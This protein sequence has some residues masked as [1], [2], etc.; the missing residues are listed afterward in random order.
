MVQIPNY[1][2]LSTESY[3]DFSGQGSAEKV[4][5][6]ILFLLRISKVFSDV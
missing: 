1:L 5:F 4:L 3:G 6:R 2:E